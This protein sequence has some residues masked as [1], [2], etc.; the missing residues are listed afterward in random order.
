ML[1]HALV[2]Q[3]PQGVI[4]VI[5]KALGNLLKM[6][7]CKN[8]DI[9]SQLVQSERGWR[10]A[11]RRVKDMHQLPDNSAEALHTTRLCAFQLCQSLLL[12]HRYIAGLLQE[13]PTQ[14]PSLFGSCEKGLILFFCTTRLEPVLPTSQLDFPS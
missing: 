6:T 7:V 13:A 14:L 2:P 9:L 3:I 4:P 8:M 5:I 12:F 1:P 10:C 11:V